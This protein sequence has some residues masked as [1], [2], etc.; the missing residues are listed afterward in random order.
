MTRKE[1]KGAKGLRAFRGFSLVSKEVA[2]V[3]IPE[4]FGVEGLH[5]ALRRAAE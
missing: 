1:A 3:T 5:R 2:E 4:K